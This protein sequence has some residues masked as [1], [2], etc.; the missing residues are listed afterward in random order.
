MAEVPSQDELQKKDRVRMTIKEFSELSGKSIR[1]VYY[2]IDNNEL[3]KIKSN[4]KT[5]VLAPGALFNNWTDLKS[6][7]FRLNQSLKDLGQQFKKHKEEQLSIDEFKEKIIFVVKKDLP[8]LVEAAI[9][10]YEKKK[11]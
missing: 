7:L 11:K 3:E 5:F 4:G 2:M 8:K 9:E 1:T 10:D 6:E